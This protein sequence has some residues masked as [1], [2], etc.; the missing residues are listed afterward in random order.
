[1]KVKGKTISTLEEM[2]ALVH[3][4]GRVLEQHFPG[5]EYVTLVHDF[6]TGM[7]NSVGSHRAMLPL[8]Q[9]TIFNVHAMAALS[10]MI[11]VANEDNL[12]AIVQERNGASL[13]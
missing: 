5:L 4:I 2:T 7:F 13:N 9:L 3:E 12:N 6:D 10:Q 1:M 8:N 11:K